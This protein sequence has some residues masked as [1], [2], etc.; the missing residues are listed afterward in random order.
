VRREAG[1][2]RRY[3]HMSTGNYNDTTARLY[4]DIGMFT[5]RETFGA[6]ASALFNYMTG[7]SEALAWR[8]IRIAPHGLRDFFY[9]MLS[10]EMENAR[11]GRPARVIAKVNSLIDEGI[12]KKLYE[13]STAGVRIDLIVRGMCSLRAGVP[14]LSE[15]ISVRSVIG[16]YLEHSRIFQFENGGIPEIYLSS[17]DWMQ[18]NLDRRVEAL[19]PV[20]Q[21]GIKRRIA[22]MLDAYLRDNAKARVM[23]SDGSYLRL[24]PA[25]GEEA[26]SVQAWLME[27]AEKAGESRFD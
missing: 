18:R 1:G 8:K 5:C 14:G 23:L 3:V 10:R 27:Q 11:A 16:R 9:A 22:E 19:F 6:D 21:D 13:A 4:T 20:E 15:N 12:I 2:I 7:Y 25:E 26:F 24:A 17:A